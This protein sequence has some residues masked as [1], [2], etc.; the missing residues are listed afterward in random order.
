M[1]LFNDRSFDE[2][3]AWRA[4]EVVAAHLAA[5]ARHRHAPVAATRRWI[6]E[7]TTGTGALPGL[8]TGHRA[9]ASG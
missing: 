8:L 5:V 1:N 9:P 2:G 3:M 7:G 4:T 6:R